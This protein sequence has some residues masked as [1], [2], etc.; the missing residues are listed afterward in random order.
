MPETRQLDEPMYRILRAQAANIAR[1]ETD[2]I[3]PGT[4]GQGNQ[5]MLWGP[6]PDVIRL[7][8]TPFRLFE[9]AALQNWERLVTLMPLLDEPIARITSRADRVFRYQV[10]F[11]VRLKDSEMTADRGQ[12]SIDGMRTTNV[13]AQKAHKL[14]YDWHHVFHDNLLLPDDDCA[15]GLVDDAGYIMS[16]EPGVEYPAALFT[17]EITG[18]RSAY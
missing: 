17:A 2:L 13:L 10:Q 6:R 15:Q 1:I 16:W 5:I 9:D 12:V 7:Y 8:D 14:I 3:L 11:L 18:T 4:D